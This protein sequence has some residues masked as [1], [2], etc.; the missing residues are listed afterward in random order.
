[1]SSLSSSICAM[2][3][4]VLKVASFVSFGHTQ[5][6]IRGDFTFDG[7]PPVGYI[8]HPR[9]KNGG[10]VIIP[11]ESISPFQNRVIAMLEFSGEELTMRYEIME[12]KS[13]VIGLATRWI[14]VV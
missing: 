6:V 12:D 9:R 1:M 5:W 13:C 10:E 14:T 7:D 11:S 3:I 8:P 4:R 2:K